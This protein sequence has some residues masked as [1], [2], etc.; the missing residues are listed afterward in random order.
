[1]LTDG[2]TVGFTVMVIG[3]EVA[4]GVVTQLNDEVITTVTTSLLAR[5]VL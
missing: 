1:M 4:V 5:V 2:T 3:A